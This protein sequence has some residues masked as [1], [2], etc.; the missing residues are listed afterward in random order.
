MKIKVGTKNKAKVDSVV[1]IVEEYPH[2]KESVIE[3]IS[4]ASGVSDQPK[5]L[6]ETING[7]MNRAKG[8]FVDCDYGIGLESGLM[9]VP[10]SKSG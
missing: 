8:V 1:E 3:G 5:S 9:S 7:A 10:M 4:I 6:E 2:L